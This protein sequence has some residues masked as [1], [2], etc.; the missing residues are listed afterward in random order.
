MS[1][2]RS[3]NKRRLAWKH[4]FDAGKGDY[5]GQYMQDAFLDQVVFKGKTDGFFLDIGANDGVTIN[6]SWF[7]ENR[8]GWK[9]ICFE[10]NPDVF[11]KLAS[12]RKCDCIEAALCDRDGEATFVKVEGGAEMLSGL[13]SSMDDDHKRRIANENSGIRHITVKTRDINSLLA[14]RGI[15]SIDLISLDIEGGELELLSKIDLSKIRVKALTIENNHKDRQMKKFMDR[16]G[17]KLIQY[18]GA[19]E[20]YVPKDWK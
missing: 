9:G 13:E 15:T 20:I 5:R 8:R 10:P 2:L 3:F 16:Y 7:F 14:E 17:F 4:K 12:N 19:D 11:A 18:L 1:L 6:N